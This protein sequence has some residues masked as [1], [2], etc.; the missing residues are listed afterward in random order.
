MKYKFKITAYTRPK[1]IVPKKKLK[2]K[3]HFY[4][5]TQT[6]YFRELNDKTCNIIDAILN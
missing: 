3:Q 4:T 1:R 6:T 5:A 2:L